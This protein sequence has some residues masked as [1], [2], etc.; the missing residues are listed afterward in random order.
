M[1]Q[2]LKYL[3]GCRGLAFLGVLFGHFVTTSHINLGRF[4]VELFF[5]LSG[6]LMA[7]ILFVRKL[8]L[9]EFF[10][11]RFARIYP[12]LFV[13]VTVVALWSQT[14]SAPIT[15][16]QYAAAIT[17]TQNYLSPVFGSVPMLQHIWSL[18]VEEHMY[19][20]LGG[21]A[22]LS[23]AT[24]LPVRPTLLA[25]AG[26]ACLD[27]LIET[28]M[29]MDYTAVYWRSDVRGAS[30]L[31]GACAYLYL[32]NRSVPPWAAPVLGAM[33]LGLSFAAVPDPVKYSLGTAALACAVATLP[34]ARETLQKT[35]SDPRLVQ[36][37][38][39]SYSLYLCQQPF[40]ITG[41]TAGG[42]Q[43]VWLIPAI[44]AALISFY[45][46]EGPARRFL[47][48]QIARFQQRA[49]AQTGAVGAADTP[50]PAV[51]R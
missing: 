1:D 20:L 49:T 51:T 25:L 23:R 17:L 34:L 33:G 13:F 9:I 19:L 24:G 12:A 4:G 37:G 40:Y 5:V 26:L 29:G 44:V 14:T 43:L 3:D 36:V 30:I 41:D 32:R 47:N 22:A 35:L 27:G 8:R 42:L 15:L 45:W 46:V 48:T 50:G 7:E 16:G 11:R 38:V 39:W 10:P 2:R 31:L 6:R 28:M 21:L 18:C